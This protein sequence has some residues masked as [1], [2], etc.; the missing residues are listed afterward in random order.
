MTKLSKKVNAG[1]VIAIG[2]IHARYDVLAATLK[3]LNG[4]GARVILLGDLIDRGGED[5]KVLNKVKE[6]LDN[7]ESIGLES[8]NVLMGNHE[9][10]FM[11][12]VQSSETMWGYNSLMLWVKNGGNLK[13]FEEMKAHY[14][15]IKQ[16]PIY[17]TVGDTMFIHAGVSPGWN[18]KDDLGHSRSVENLLWMREPF[19]SVGPELNKWTDKVKK[20]VHG[21]TIV[22]KEPDVTKDRIGIDTG[23]V[24]SG[25]LTAYNATQ[26]TYWQVKKKKTVDIFS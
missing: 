10:M 5:M 6:L 4:T 7:P 23:A 24:F 14:G 13:Q 26:D 17:M 19:L 8:F 21:H 15:W 20:V 3:W 1:D 16:L 12:A 25:I 9:R 11:E 22:G 2:D 18:P